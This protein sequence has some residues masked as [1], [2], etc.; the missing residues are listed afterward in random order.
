MEPTP[1]DIRR[2][3]FDMVRRGYDPQAVAA[4]LEEIADRMAELDRDLE[5]A[6]ARLGTVEDALADAKAAEEALQLTMVAATQAK[7]EMLAKAKDE[8]E[9]M[10]REAKHESESALG[11]ARREALEL[12]ETSRREADELTETSRKEADELTET[13]R[14]E[15][16]ELTE[17]SRRE[18]EQLTGAREENLAITSDVER[19]KGVIAT[20]RDMLLSAVGTAE[21]DLAS[22]ESVARAEGPVVVAEP[23]AVQRRRRNCRSPSPNRSRKVSKIMLGRRNRRQS[24][25]KRPLPMQSPSRSKKWLLSRSKT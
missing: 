13:S 7:D 24:L 8:S 15:A 12:I 3:T 19:L 4:Y 18:A 25:L 21:A 2:K 11:E 6:Q 17:T 20:T 14:R 23:V 9:R 5:Q 10:I 1:S 22:A 16:D